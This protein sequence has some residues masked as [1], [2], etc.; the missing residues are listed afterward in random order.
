MKVIQLT[1]YGCSKSNVDMGAAGLYTFITR[2]NYSALCW[3]LD[4][5][6][7]IGTPV[8]SGLMLVPEVNILVPYPIVSEKLGAL[9]LIENHPGD[10]QFPELLGTKAFL[11]W[12]S[13]EERS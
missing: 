8:L 2:F 3:S 13:A 4:I 10:Y 11:V 7:A 6:D 12:E 9:Y 5:L 1:S